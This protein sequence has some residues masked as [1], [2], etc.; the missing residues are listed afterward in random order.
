M[1]VAT[2]SPDTVV[3]SPA[4]SL[5]PPEVEATARG[6]LAGHGETA[7]IRALEY[8]GIAKA[9]GAHETAESWRRVYRAIRAIRQNESVPAY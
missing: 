7:E 5:L 9:K 6:L 2:S 1:I 8:A 3:Q 4:R